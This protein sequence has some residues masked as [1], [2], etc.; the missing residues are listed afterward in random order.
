MGEHNHEHVHEHHHDHENEH[1]HEHHSHEEALALLTYMVGHNKHHTE[2]LHD[3]A[4][5]TDGEAAQLLHEA[6]SQY[7]QAN[8]KLEKALALLKDRGE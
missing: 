3:I 4:H 2:E 7:T 1:C 8:E 5:S 6:V